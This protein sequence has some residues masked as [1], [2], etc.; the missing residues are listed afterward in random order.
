[1][2]KTI[3]TIPIPERPRERCLAKGASALSLRECLAL[4]L[5]SGPRGQGCMGLA[6]A[7]LKCA[8]DGM[9][10]QDEE[11]A[12]FTAMETSGF[13]SLK[14]IP[15]LGEAGQ[16]RIL[17]SFELGRRYALLRNQRNALSGK[18]LRLSYL[19]EASVAK[20][21]LS[22]RNEP[23]E[24]LGF[25]CL[26]RSG[27]LSE[28]CIVERGT[29]THVN[30]D[31]AELFA[32]LLALRPRAFFLFHNHPSN[33]LTPSDPDM[34]LTRRVRQ[35]ARLLGIELLGHAIVSPC[36]ENWIDVI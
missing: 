8:G 11:R 15:G 13:A 36:G 10:A 1:M 18:K 29:R 34:D 24:W 35:M 6:S 16:T 9:T 28:L 23:Q 12:F 27:D 3:E 2:D 33:D 14:N 17:A 25:V 30:V 20:I 26:Y 21:H 19:A 22:W 4:I 7:I 31:P 5:G 32:R